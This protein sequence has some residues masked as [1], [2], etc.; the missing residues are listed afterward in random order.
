MFKIGFQRIGAKLINRGFVHTGGEVVPDFL[1]VR[2]AA[3]SVPGQIVQNAPQKSL[4][5]LS[6]LAVNAPARLVGWNRVFLH[7][8]AATVLVE[9]DTGVGALIHEFSV[10]SRSVRH[11]RNWSVGRRRGG[12]RDRLT[13]GPRFGVGCCPVR[14]CSLAEGRSRKGDH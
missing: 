6:E 13:E 4:I 11:R 12:V 14:R 7:P 1:L 3:R 9:I 2:V 8:A 5:I 10:Q